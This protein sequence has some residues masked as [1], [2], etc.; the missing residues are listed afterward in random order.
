MATTG[1]ENAETL[2]WSLSKSISL[3]V[4]AVTTISVCLLSAVTTTSVCLLAAGAM[5]YNRDALRSTMRRCHFESKNEP[6][7]EEAAA[8][9]SSSCSH[10]G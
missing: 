2:L 8:A 3:L 4:A 1:E 7:L 5:R 9:A 6:S 10:A